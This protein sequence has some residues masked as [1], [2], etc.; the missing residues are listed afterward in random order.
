MLD[1]L[2]QVATVEAQWDMAGEAAATL[3]NNGV[4]VPLPDIILATSAVHHGLTL[5][6]RDAHFIL[7]QTILPALKLFTEPP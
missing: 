7:M 2:P 1:A 3:R 5:W 6:T 4:N